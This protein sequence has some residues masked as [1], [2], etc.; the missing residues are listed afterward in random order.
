M[1]QAR[2]VNATAARQRRKGADKLEIRDK[3]NPIQECQKVIRDDGLYKEVYDYLKEWALNPAADSRAVSEAVRMVCSCMN[4]LGEIAARDAWFEK[5][6][7]AHKDKP[8]VL[9]AL[10]TQNVNDSN[11]AMIDDHFVRGVWQGRCVRSENR[12]RVWSLQRMVH[13]VKLL[14]SSDI[15]QKLTATELIRFYHSFLNILE[16]NSPWKLQ[17]LTDLE[18]VPDYEEMFG[19]DY[20]PISPVDEAG[21][22]VFY[23]VPKTWEQAKSDGERLMWVVEQLANVSPNGNVASLQFRSSFAQRLFGVQTLNEYGY[24][25]RRDLDQNKDQ[26]AILS[27]E[28]LTDD[29]TIARLAAGVKRFKLPAGYDYVN[30]L[31]NLYEQLESHREKYDVGWEL[32]QEYMNRRQY[33][34]AA[35]WLK[36]MFSLDLSADNLKSIRDKY[37][38]IVG[39]RGCFD[40]TR[41]KAAGMAIDLYWT[42]RNGK[43]ARFTATRI[44]IPLLLSDI[45]DYIRGFN[46]KDISTLDDSRLQIESIG[47]QILLEKGNAEKY[48]KETEAVWEVKLDPAK[49][50]C[51]RQ[52]AVELPFSKP[53]AWLVQGTMA[54]GNSDSIVVWINDT[55]IV[56]KS[57]DHAMLYY[58]ADAKTGKPLPN[59]DLN[60]FQFGQIDIRKRG[61]SSSR[62]ERVGKVDEFTAAT[63]QEG[64][65]IYRNN[66]EDRL[67]NAIWLI[68]TG[69]K[70]T[71]Q[72]QRVAWLGFKPIWFRGDSASQLNQDK[73]YVIVDRPAYRPE[74]KVEY[75]IWVGKA[76][77]DLPYASQWAKKK[78][79]LSVSD[80]RHTV[81]E[82]REITLDDKGGYTS[83]LELKKDAMLGGYRMSILQ[84]K[85][86]MHLGSASFYVEEYRKP[87]YEVSVD[88]PK[89]PVTLGDKFTAK[90]SAR[91]YFGAPVTQARVKYTVT[92]TRYE[93]FWCPV[94]PWDWFYGNGYWWFG[95]D[96]TWYPGWN[97]WGCPAPRWP[98]IHWNRRE[99]TEVVVSETVPIN[100]DGT[101]DVAIDSTQA[102]ELYPDD[103]HQYEISTEV[104]DSSRRVIRASSSVFVA[105]TPFK[106]FSWLRGGFF[107]P[108]QQI[109][110]CVQAR[111]L[112]GKAVSGNAEYKLYRI[113]YR[114]K[115]DG[116]GVEPVEKVIWSGSGKVD[117]K[118]VAEVQLKAATAGQYR[119]SAKVTD[120]RE[121]TAEGAYS[122]TIHGQGTES[123]DQFEFNA[124][125][126][127]PDK[128]EYRVGDTA[129]LLIGSKEK[130][131]SVLLFTRSN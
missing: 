43:S 98:W 15:R 58:V 105:R 51:A 42:F 125:E 94:R 128:E 21:N 104:T 124:I 118:G 36:R 25:F 82:E 32:A 33:P 129:R 89:E 45:K 6:L 63:N 31:K 14:E 114:T 30:I 106:V 66:Q 68:Q 26:S 80:P 65:Y 1:N 96:Y 3:T 115:K 28:T 102:K 101:I 8:L 54:S 83:C 69:A 84:S 70:N 12:D 77:F 74:Q 71:D 112:D 130:D 41:S 119:F 56:E 52:V 19:T 35:D 55:A 110:A 97:N 116:K 121:R 95:S 60:F 11:G 46:G 53:G 93:S 81:M 122:F 92:R 103:D 50:H 111:R 27:L 4:Q 109:T 123:D 75:K 34:K 64:Q 17:V 20:N 108:G 57:L 29:E 47:Y 88:A 37:D 126:L 38:D 72:T 5:I 48:L 113:T 59:I 62:S 10:A 39:N 91:Y 85:G 127:I 131:A 120:A 87:E 86:K 13:A 78:V 22:P 49:G 40:S 73:A 61:V 79:W 117:E 24:M 90:I 67:A 9:C 23:A 2:P 44:D 18:K 100:S 7:A 107:E 99:N 76:Q 16:E